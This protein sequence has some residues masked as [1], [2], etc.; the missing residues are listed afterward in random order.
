MP[1]A[2]TVQLGDRLYP[3]VPQPHAR[4]RH[5]LSTADFQ[6]ILSRDYASEAY[7]ILSVLVPAILPEHGGITEW[8][9]D[10]FSNEQDW[11]KYKA[12]DMTVYDDEAAGKSPTPAQIIDAFEKSLNVSGAGRLGKLLTLIQ[13]TTQAVSLAQQTDTLPP[14]H[15]DT[16]ESPSMSSGTNPPT[17]TASAA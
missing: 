14:S 4:L 10:G 17:S 3:V 11:H 7:R 12:G 1:E 5:R 6:K 8:E 9:F 2:V 13:G 16:G 15:G